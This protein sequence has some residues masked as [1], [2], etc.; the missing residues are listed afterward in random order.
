[1]AVGA[2]MAAVAACCG[3]QRFF[4]P[5]IFV[6]MYVPPRL[7]VPLALSTVKHTEYACLCF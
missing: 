7:C 6:R 1:M 2:V 3:W 5:K 4:I